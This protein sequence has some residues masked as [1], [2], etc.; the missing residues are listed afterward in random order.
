MEAIRATHEW[1]G[2]YALR[3][4]PF[5]AVCGFSMGTSLA[6]SMALY[7]AVEAA[8]EEQVLGSGPSLPFRAAIFICGGLPLPVLEDLGLKVTC[9]AQE[10]HLQTAKQLQNTAGKLSD[11]AA[12]PELIKPGVG[13]WDCLE[14]QLLH[15]PTVRP[16]RSDVFGLDFTSFPTSARIRIPTVHIYGA[17]DP[18]WPSGI[19]LAEFCDD[20]VEFDHGGG[21]DIPRATAVSNK[22][23]D[24]I[25]QVIGRVQKV[26]DKSEQRCLGLNESVGLG[27]RSSALAT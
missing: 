22:I 8:N 3:N 16:D 9:R 6:A 13:L 19:Q 2:N 5:D 20:K 25:K 17:K 18:R 11:Y 10:I 15:D 14:G 1:L 4:G 21:H 27:L 24:M 12:N 23:A 7:H 26:E